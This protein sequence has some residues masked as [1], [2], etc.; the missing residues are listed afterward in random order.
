MTSILFVFVT[1]CIII[2]LTSLSIVNATHT[3]HQLPQKYT[4]KAPY[5]TLYVYTFPE[6]K[7]CVILEH[8]GKV[9]QA[10]E[11]DQ[12]QIPGNSS[13]STDGGKCI[14]DTCQVQTQNRPTGELKPN[15]R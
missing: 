13:N 6:T 2:L 3:H 7:E 15:Q 5:T 10:Q 9:V 11:Q 12:T 4:C 1:I 8:N 14:G